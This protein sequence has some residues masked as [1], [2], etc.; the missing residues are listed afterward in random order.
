MESLKLPCEKDQEQNRTSELGGGYHVLGNKLS[1]E[2]SPSVSSS[3]R[4]FRGMGR[5][6]PIYSSTQIRK[7][8]GGGD[9]VNAACRGGP[10]L[11]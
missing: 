5:D 11:A 7:P 2:M 6:F 4:R 10:S 9:L 3:K 8:E 1:T